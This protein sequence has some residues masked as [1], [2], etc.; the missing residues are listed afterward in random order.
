[1][2]PA[3]DRDRTQFGKY[4]LVERLGRGGMA[5]VWKARISGP[6]G[7]QRTYQR[8]MPFK[9][10]KHTADAR[11]LYAIDVPAKNFFVRRKYFKYHVS[12][13]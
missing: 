12:G 7:F 10:F 5:D 13:F 1:M 2:N 4:T 3:L 6:A 8:G 11:Q 9:H